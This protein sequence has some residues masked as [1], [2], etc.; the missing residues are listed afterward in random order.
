MLLATAV[1]HAF[2]SV[3]A[4]PLARTPMSASRLLTTSVTEHSRNPSLAPLTWLRREAVFAYDTTRYPFAPLARAILEQHATGSAAL[5]SD[6]SDLHMVVAGIERFVDGSGNELNALQARWNS[7]RCRLEDD[8]SSSMYGALDNVYHAFVKEVVGP[9]MGG[10]RIVYQRS[11]TIRIYTP[12]AEAMGKLH[13]DCA[14]HHQPS[15]L[16]FWL[17]LCDVFATNSLWVESEEN[18][19][20]FH[21]LTMPYGSYA[22][23]YGNKCRHLTFPNDTGKT[24]VSLDFRA[25]SAASGGH[26]PN[27]RRGVRRGV[28]ARFQ[29]VFDVGGFYVECQS[30]PLPATDFPWIGTDANTQ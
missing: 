20:D 30:E 8:P 18:L 14:Y 22:R 28:K 24:R 27:F 12:S 25:V 15:E 7:N 2:A 16:N 23:F 11:P 19:G 26:D 17:P 29:N 5:P 9:M 21:P 10:G 13:N 6:L 4:L 3:A 1:F